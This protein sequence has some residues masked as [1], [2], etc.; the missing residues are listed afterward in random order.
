[1]DNQLMTV[2]ISEYEVRLSLDTFCFKLVESLNNSHHFRWFS[3]TTPSCM[4]VSRV[5]QVGPL[6][7]TNGSTQSGGSF[8]GR[9]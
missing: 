5:R 6:C 7:V 1:M 2:A 3:V 4:T 8:Y 9:E